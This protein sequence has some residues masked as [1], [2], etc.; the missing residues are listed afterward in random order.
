MA[1]TSEANCLA[2]ATEWGTPSLIVQAANVELLA[3]WYTQFLVMV[4]EGTAIFATS[5]FLQITSQL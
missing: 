4:K 1:V 5:R 2:F 3:G